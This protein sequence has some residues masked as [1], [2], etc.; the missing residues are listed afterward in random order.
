MR[1]GLMGGTFDPVHLGH[2]IGAETV[3]DELDLDRV[4]FVPAAAP[5]H[6]REARISNSVHRVKM[7]KLAVAGNDRFDVCTDEIERGGDSYTIDTVRSFSGKIVAKGELFFILGQDNLQEFTTWKDWA[8]ICSNCRLVS[9]RRQ[10]G[11]KDYEELPEELGEVEVIR[12]EMPIIGISATGI[13]RRVAQGLSIR[14]QVPLPVAEYIE[15]HGLYAEAGQ[16]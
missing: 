5:P 10:G 8:G 13:R 3:A 11:G 4:L 16:L 2:L 15:S 9:L 1:I 6:K 14:Y 7:L 12:I